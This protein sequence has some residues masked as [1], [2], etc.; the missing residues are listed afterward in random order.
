MAIIILKWAPRKKNL[1]S[2]ISFVAFF[3]F[4]GKEVKRNKGEG[5]KKHENWGDMYEVAGYI[6]LPLNR[7]MGSKHFEEDGN[8]ESGRNIMIM[9]I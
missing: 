1:R 2:C 5:R 4:V 8:R 7:V 6:V 3:V 9:R